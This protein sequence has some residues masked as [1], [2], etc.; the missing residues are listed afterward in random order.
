[1]KL[2]SAADAKKLVEHLVQMQLIP[3]VQRPQNDLV[4]KQGLEAI[5]Q[6]MAKEWEK[7]VPDSSD[8]SNKKLE[9][10]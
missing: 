7:A 5:L 2:P 4:L 9:T 3:V 1:V 10:V 8:A 6:D